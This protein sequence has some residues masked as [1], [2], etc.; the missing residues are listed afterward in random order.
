MTSLPSSGIYNAILRRSNGLSRTKPTKPKRRPSASDRQI[1]Q[2]QRNRTTNRSTMIPNEEKIGECHRRVNAC[3]PSGCAPEIVGW[4]PLVLEG[5]FETR[6]GASVVEEFVAGHDASDV[7]RPSR[8]RGGRLA[9]RCASAAGGDA[10]DRVPAPRYAG[11]GRQHCG[12]LPQ[13]RSLTRR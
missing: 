7:L 12:R 3:R 8:R 4:S 13:R 11:G 1:S 5:G 9:A 6:I 10:G 2:S